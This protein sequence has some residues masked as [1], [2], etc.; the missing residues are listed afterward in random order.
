MQLARCTG[1]LVRQKVTTASELGLSGPKPFSLSLCISLKCCVDWRKSCGIVQW[2]LLDSAGVAP[3]SWYWPTKVICAGIGRDQGCRR[4][5]LLPGRHSARIGVEDIAAAADDEIAGAHQLIYHTS[6][7]VM[8]ETRSSQLDLH[9]AQQEHHHIQHV[10]FF[11]S[12]GRGVIFVIR[13]RC[14]LRGSLTSRRR[15]AL[16]SVTGASMSQRSHLAVIE[17]T[18]IPDF[19]HALGGGGGGGREVGAGM[20]AEDLVRGS[21]HRLQPAARSKLPIGSCCHVYWRALV[22]PEGESRRIL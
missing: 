13:R 20:V 15:A 6:I 12:S 21:C 9:S 18:I 16:E 22:M 10:Q 4:H 2:P 8:A 17:V 19:A 1:L 11:L 5:C 7:V 3:A 14:I